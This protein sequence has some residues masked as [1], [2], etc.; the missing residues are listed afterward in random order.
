MRTVSA[1]WTLIWTFEIDRHSISRVSVSRP[2]FSVLLFEFI[3]SQLCRASNVKRGRCSYEFVTPSTLAIPSEF[4]LV[5]IHRRQTTPSGTKSGRQ[6]P[7]F[8]GCDPAKG[9]ANCLSNGRLPTSTY[10]LSPSRACPRLSLPTENSQTIAQHFPTSRHT[11]S[12]RRI[13]AGKKEGIWV[14]CYC[15]AI[16]M[17]K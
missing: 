12:H 11:D 8:T 2:S 1:R 6:I 13:F 14:I 15:S 16:E 5:K 3:R 7:E 17:P 9:S 10:V 4:I